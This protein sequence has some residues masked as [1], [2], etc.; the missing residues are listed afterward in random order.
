M[1]NSKDEIAKRMQDSAKRMGITL[2]SFEKAKLTPEQINKE[3]QNYLDADIKAKELIDN[4]NKKFGYEAIKKLEGEDI[5]NKLFLH[6]PDKDNMCYL[7]EYDND[8]HDYFGSIWGGSAKKHGL[9]LSNKDG[10]WHID[11][12]R[13]LTIEEA[14]NE[15]TKIRDSILT[16]Y[17]LI[18]REKNKLNNVN[19]Y[20]SLFN[21]LENVTNNY[22]RFVTY[23]KYYQIIFPN[24]FPCF[25]S[26]KIQNVILGLFG[27]TCDD[28]YPTRTS[29]IQD[30]V[31][32]SK[33]S[34]VVFGQ[35]LRPY[36]K[37]WNAKT[38]TDGIDDIDDEDDENTDEMYDEYT[39]KDFLKEA[40]INEVD[41]EDIVN[42]LKYKKNIILQGPPGVGKSFIAKK[43]AY[44]MIGEK[45]TYRVENIQFHQS[46]G[47]E[48]FIM[49]YKPIEGGFK[50]SNGIFYEFC[51]KA[52]ESNEPFYFIIDEINRGNLSKIF[53]ELLMLIEGDKRKESVKLAYRNEYFNVPE[54]VYLIGMMNTADRSISIL[55]YALRR[56][57]SFY[58]IKPV[59]GE[60]KFTEYLRTFI[61]DEKY[62][63]KINKG[64]AKLN[65]KIAD[66]SYSQLGEG[67][68]I[69]HSYFCNKPNEGQSIEDWYNKI[70]KYEIE[71]L[72]K[73][74]WWD[75]PDKV[76]ECL[77]LIK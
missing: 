55:D 69:G 77:K 51:K 44:S 34:D 32:K 4:F 53:G 23:R 9:Y 7:L 75:T 25:Y 74:Y 11:S 62:I 14:I 48:D 13:I 43:L 1:V 45:N 47:Y 56:R 17:E 19:D 27:V 2:S 46:Y 37:D 73:E 31:I 8:L 65:E 42:L 58:D 10:Q 16:G 38:T 20:I 40:F 21:K 18:E 28:D 39:K 3:A 22:I 12:K 5:L 66:V 76:E 26:R 30:L 61:D 52:A 63:E 57:F 70:I 15:G 29:Y 64:F 54:N 59:F 50:L 60:D 68:C 72:L 33:V 49:G 24:L 35:T 6:N 41:Y 71:P 67:F 36:L